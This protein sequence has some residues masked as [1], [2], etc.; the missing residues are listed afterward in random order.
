MDIWGRKIQ[1]GI[2]FFPK[3]LSS[4]KLPT[5]L[6]DSEFLMHLLLTIFTSLQCNVQNNILVS[7]KFQLL[8]HM[9]NLDFLK[10]IFLREVL[11]S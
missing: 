9:L 2:H 7:D 3:W 8:F 11:D 4:K 10:N 6:Y 1:E 5:K